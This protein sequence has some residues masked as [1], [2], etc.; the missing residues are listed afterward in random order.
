MRRIIESN[1]ICVCNGLMSPAV[2]INKFEE[3]Y[4]RARQKLGVDADAMAVATST[5]H[6]APSIRIL[7]FRGMHEEKFYF[8]TNYQSRKGKNLEENP[9]A[10]VV[11]LWHT[12]GLQVNL[13]GPVTKITPAESDLYFYHRSLE[14]QLSAAASKQSRPLES[15][16][17][18]LAEIES[19]RA[20][21]AGKPVRPSHWGGYALEARRIEFWTMREHRRHEREAFLRAKDQWTREWLYP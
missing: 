2:P 14:S 6:G 13:E 7:Y 11:F 9:Q 18:Y 5:S 12:M 8:Y 4:Q 10:A 3:W 21:T 17:S 15:Y 1:P 16:G 20:S 19:L